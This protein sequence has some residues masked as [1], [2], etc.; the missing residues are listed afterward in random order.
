MELFQHRMSVTLQGGTVGLSISPLHCPYCLTVDQADTIAKMLR[1][2][3]TV[4]RKMS[5]A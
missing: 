4:A 3:V 5:K 1:K 2:A